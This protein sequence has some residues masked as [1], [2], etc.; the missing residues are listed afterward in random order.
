M[1][2]LEKIK[3]WKL[4]PGDMAIHAGIAAL[5]VGLVGALI[6]AL[7][8]PMVLLMLWACVV[9][10]VFYVRESGQQMKKAHPPT[11]RWDITQWGPRGIAEYVCVLP[12][13]IIVTV[14]IVI[15]F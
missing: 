4:E 2:L 5:A 1:S 6:I 8:L 11:N 12:A 15:Y 14:I 3:D 10:A 13:V 9:Q 7:S